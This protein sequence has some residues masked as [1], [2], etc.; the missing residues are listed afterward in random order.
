MV[1]LAHDE[2]LN[3][4]VALKEIQDRHTE[5]E[6]SRSRLLLEAGIAGG[7]EHPSIVP[8]YG[9]DQYADGRPLCAMRFIKVDSLRDAIEKFHKGGGKINERPV[10]FREFLERAVAGGRSGMIHDGL[11]HSGKIL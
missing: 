5:N 8:V 10:E 9:L 11:C 4:D 1:Y 2:E 7:L 3:R 6:D